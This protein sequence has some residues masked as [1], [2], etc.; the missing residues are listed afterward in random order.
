MNID[1]KEINNVISK[2]KIHESWE[3]IVSG[4]QVWINIEN[5]VNVIQ[6]VW[7]LEKHMIKPRDEV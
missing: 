6:Q 2:S 7:I 4:M 3:P 5:S 1:A